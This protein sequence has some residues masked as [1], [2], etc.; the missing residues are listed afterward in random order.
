MN[1]RTNYSEEKLDMLRRKAKNRLRLVFIFSGIFFLAILLTQIVY[2]WYESHQ[3]WSH[4]RYIA[5]Y[6]IILN[7][8]ISASFTFLASIVFYT[9]IA[10]R[11]A[12]RFKNAYKD[13]YVLDAVRSVELYEDLS[14]DRKSGISFQ[15][16]C[17]A[18]VVD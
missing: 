2:S 10:D 18:F 5:P 8:V 17:S 13:S 15:E 4:P 12:D 9:F 3:T 1:E 14:Y 16:I 6:Q 7:T 11:S